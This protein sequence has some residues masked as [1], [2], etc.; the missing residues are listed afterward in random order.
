MSR[1]SRAS[2]D[3]LR[4][5]VAGMGIGSG[6]A[7][8]RGVIA[9]AAVG[10]ATSGALAVF[11]RRIVRDYFPLADEWSILAH[12][13][14]RVADVRSWFTEGFRN[15]FTAPPG[16][17]AVPGGSF[18][19]PL[20]NA[21]Y[22]AVGRVAGP[23]SSRY[24]RIGQVAVGACAGLTT[25]AVAR[26][27]GSTREAVAA[28][29]L[30]P[31]MPAFVPSTA[32]LLYPCMAFDPMTAGL[33]QS[34]IIAYDAG[35]PRTAAALLAAGVLTKETALPTASVLPALFALQH[36]H[37][38]LR[39]S[40]TRR[41][42]AALSAP[43][44]LWYAANRAA[45]GD[46]TMKE[47]AYV[48]RDDPRGRI[49]RQLRLA[50]KFP[51]W[52][53]GGAR[54]DAAWTTEKSAAAAQLAANV[55]VMGGAA[56]E[57]ATR[58]RAGRELA[59]DE[60]SFLASY[61]FMNAVGISPRYGVTLDI[62]LITSLARWVRESDRTSTA[63]KAVAA[64]LAL[65]VTAN[66]VLFA[67][68]FPATRRNFSAYADVGRRYV[69]ALRQ[70]GAG[71]RVLVLNDPITF[72]APTRW[73]R[74]ALTIEADVIKLADHAWSATNLEAITTPSTVH[75][76]PPSQPGQPWRFTHTLGLD[77]LSAHSRLSHDADTHVDYGN[78]VTIDLEAADPDAPMLDGRHRWKAMRIMPGDGPVH[79]LYFD[80]QA[81]DFRSVTV[82]PEPVDA[83]T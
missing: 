58:L 50:S 6:R 7:P 10:A 54:R 27:G 61:A 35:R 20:F 25:W 15:Y 66:A 11:G 74:R 41:A 79:L 46:T 42:L 28:G 2:F 53:D 38:V 47:G 60:G 29:A 18:S 36:R 65:G 3:P 76:E 39:D 26:S 57:I 59:T 81:R 40:R 83:S 67:R 16:L 22:W 30:V 37:D 73:L 44:P 51:F 80:P 78:G 13:H 32:M 17:P 48:L 31:A 14:P 68:T 75:L 71:D 77:L 24:L 23:E 8:S 12:S 9:G 64:G 63:V 52:V 70:F 82:E 43:V 1:R 55:L 69:A 49:V 45:F 56:T 5:E 21:T 72:W 33:S 4:A 62:S 19:R 34:A